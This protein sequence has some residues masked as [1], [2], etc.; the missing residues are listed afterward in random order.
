MCNIYGKREDH[1]IFHEM[2]ETDI[3]QRRRK[4]RND[5]LKKV[6]CARTI[7][8]WKEIT[9]WLS[10]SSSSIPTINCFES[11]QNLISYTVRFCVKK[12]KCSKCPREGV[13]NSNNSTKYL[14]GQQWPT[15]LQH[16]SC[17]I[18][19]NIPIKTDIAREFTIL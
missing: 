4:V 16:S 2:E 14:F 5:D 12:C 13:N 18:S 7:Q 19:N 1:K 8:N 6:K 9:Q 15:M 3:Q 11:T 10:T 17:K